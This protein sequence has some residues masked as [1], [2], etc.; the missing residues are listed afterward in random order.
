MRNY[1]RNNFF[2]KFLI[3]GNSIFIL[4]LIANVGLYFIFEIILIVYLIFFQNGILFSIIYLIYKILNLID[5][6]NQ[7]IHPDFPFGYE[8]CQ[9]IND[10]LSNEDLVIITDEICNTK[11]YQLKQFIQNISKSFCYDFDE[12]YDNKILIGESFCSKINEIYNLQFNANDIAN[13]ITIL[14][15]FQVLLI[16]FTKK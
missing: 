1:Y 13:I 8:N 5:K 16:I 7:Y 6:M 2:N 3:I 9:K 4:F 15:I 12:Y 11:N 10:G 14:V